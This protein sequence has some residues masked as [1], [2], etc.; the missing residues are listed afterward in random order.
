LD[1]SGNSIA[2]N[3]VTRYS[4][5]CGVAAEFCVYAD[6]YEITNTIG[7]TSLYQSEYDVYTGSSM[8]APQVSGAIALLSEAFPNHTPA[9]LVDRILATANNNFYTK[10]GDTTFINGITH[11]Y[12]AEFGHGIVDLELAL[13][14]INSSSMIP[15]DSGI[16]STGNI[17]NAKRYDLSTSILNLPASFGDAFQNS[18]NGETAYFYDSLNG[19]FAFNLGSLVKTNILKTKNAFNSYVNRSNYKK[20]L[21]DGPLSFVS[22]NDADNIINKNKFM[23]IYE[24]NKDKSS[25]IGNNINIQNMLSFSQREENVINGIS[26][27]NIM[28]IPFLKS[29]DNGVSLGFKNTFNQNNNITYGYFS[30][31]S[32]EFL[33][34][35]SGFIAEYSKEIK[36]SNL[37]VFTGSIIEKNGF[38]ESSM[39]GG[40]AEK[41][42]TT[43]N[44]IGA[45]GYG[46]LNDIWSYDIMATAGVSNFNLQESGLVRDISDVLSSAF[47]VEVSK[48]LNFNKNDSIHFAVN[49]PIRLEKGT[50]EID[51]PGL[52]SKGGNLNFRRKEF[53][54]SP[55]GRQIDLSIGYKTEVKYG[56]NIIFKLNLTKDEGHIAS[57]EITNSAMVYF[58]SE[59]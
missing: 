40:I 34:P 59:F 5:Q 38:L 28:A 44:F 50:A 31:K 13:G 18:L 35:T 15:R 19:G 47:A 49:Q 22:V 52:Y 45:T 16:V 24:V 53:S 37:S 14:V 56:G 3:T 46:W 1:V 20:I 10:S 29:S 39:S 12:N 25:F 9:Q 11:G 6:G 2:S 54:I 51:V 23:S 57:G 7:S 32:D 4:N 27:N 36:S 41:S 17:E 42:S 58:Q 8:S 33:V 30:G 26:N 55:S 43:T 21:Q 48:P